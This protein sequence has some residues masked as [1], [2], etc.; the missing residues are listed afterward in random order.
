MLPTPARASPGTG[1]A[2][3]CE[4]SG[5]RHGPTPSAFPKR[6]GSR[7]DFDCCRRNA[8]ALNSGLPESWCSRDWEV[9]QPP[10]LPG[11]VEF[12]VEWPACGHSPGGHVWPRDAPASLNALC[13][14]KNVNHRQKGPDSTESFQETTRFART[15][16]EAT[17]L[18]PSLSSCPEEKKRTDGLCRAR[19]NTDAAGV[20]R[21]AM[22]TC[23][24]CLSGNA[25]AHDTVLQ[26]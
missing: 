19:R 16:A 20:Q 14:L 11:G 4:G 26:W 6:P 21:V 5:T 10:L 9:P 3:G 12:Q 7:T 2:V 1:P 22:N 17:R 18:C 23:G 24:A 13:R 15:H 8:M 25:V